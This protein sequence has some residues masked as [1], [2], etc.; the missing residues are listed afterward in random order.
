MPFPLRGRSATGAF[1]SATLVVIS[2][3]V[4]GA[5]SAAAA[6]EPGE[7]G[8]RWAGHD[9]REVDSVY[10]LPPALQSVLGV[11]KSGLKAIADR[12]ENY[13]PTD[14]IYPNLPTRRFLVAGVDGA[15]ALVAVERGGFIEWLDVLL[16]SDINEKPT[17]KQAWRL[18][19]H[20]NDLRH[21]V[22][23]LRTR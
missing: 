8:V 16:F 5:L 19:R 1:V 18:S 7:T 14:V 9:I 3:I 22:N 11:N 13:N 21:L 4:V 15:S 6:T 23:Q 17:V 12:G 10:A 20:P 2:A